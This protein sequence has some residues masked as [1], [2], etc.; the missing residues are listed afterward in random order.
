M[1]PM[2]IAIKVLLAGIASVS[3]MAHAQQADLGKLEYMSSC[4]ACHGVSGEGNGPYAAM[5][6]TAVA[7]LTVLTKKNNGVFPYQR[8][9]ESIDGRLPVKAHGPSDM[10]IWGATYLARDKVYY[11]ENSPA[12]EVVVRS[13]IL[14]LAEYIS[15]LQVK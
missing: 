8:V 7:N 2:S 1:K 10:P 3:V 15:R 14:A 11:T 5:V 9:Y 4:V 13:R 6:N 12:V